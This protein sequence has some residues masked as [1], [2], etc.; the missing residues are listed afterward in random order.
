APNITSAF[1]VAGQ[2]AN[3]YGRLGLDRPHIV[4]LDAFHELAVRDGVLTVGAGF[5][6]ES[7][8]AYGPLG[9]TNVSGYGPG[10]SFLLP[11]GS[12]HRTPMTAQL[13]VHLGYRR[14]A[15]EGFVNVFNLTNQQDELAVD[16]VYTYDAAN[17]VVGGT[18]VDLVHLKALEPAGFH[19]NGIEK[20][21]T[22]TVN[23]N[24]G[25]T[26]ARQAP[27]NVQFGVRWRF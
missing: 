7:G 15:V 10:E 22:V 8:I 23:K 2:V 9:A 16:S 20:R 27:R 13:D 4:K 1:D 6:A 25:N 18:P 14:S 11:R 19:P 5:R 17:P 24:F 21:T 12:L 26:I 3:R